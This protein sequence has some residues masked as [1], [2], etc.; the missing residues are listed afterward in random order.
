MLVTDRLGLRPEINDLNQVL[1]LLSP[2]FEIRSPA[3][4]MTNVASTSPATPSGICEYELESLPNLATSSD[5]DLYNLRLLASVCE[6]VSN[7]AWQTTIWK[8]WV[9]LES[10]SSNFLQNGGGWWGTPTSPRRIKF[11]FGLLLAFSRSWRLLDFVS[12]SRT[13]DVRSV[14]RGQQ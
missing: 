5:N 11:H 10:N 8:C 1:T 13:S 2:C 14:Y 9:H 4:H 12:T 7:Y 3:E 6:Q